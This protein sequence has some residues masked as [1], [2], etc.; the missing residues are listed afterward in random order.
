VV[1]IGFRAIK[2]L[3]D[4]IIDGKRIIVVDDEPDI[5]VVLRELL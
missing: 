4:Y 3:W 5:L 1:G 2:K